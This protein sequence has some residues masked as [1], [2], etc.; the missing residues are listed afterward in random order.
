MGFFDAAE[1]ARFAADAVNPQ[2]TLIA[3]HHPLGQG[4]RRKVGC[5]YLGGE[6]VLEGDDNLGIVLARIRTA[7]G[8]DNAV[9]RANG[10]ADHV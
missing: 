10:G 5:L 4:Q 6:P 8:L 3:V 9:H 1:L 7:Q 2:G